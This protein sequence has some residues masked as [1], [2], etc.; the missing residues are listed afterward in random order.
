M[1][2]HTHVRHEERHPVELT[3]KKDGEASVVVSRPD[4]LAVDVHQAQKDA[5]KLLDAAMKHA[6][7][8]GDAIATYA[9]KVDPA[10]LKALEAGDRSALKVFLM[11]A[12]HG[13]DN[14]EYEAGDGKTALKEA[15]SPLTS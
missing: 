11:K 13:I 7:V 5:Q 3:P 15:L 2:R 6:E 12:V 14:F 1:G 8:Q 10:R 4:G 9:V